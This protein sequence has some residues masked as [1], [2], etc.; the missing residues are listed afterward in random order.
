MKFRMNRFWQLAYPVLVYYLCYNLLY[1]LFCS[2]FAKSCS[3]LFLL[4]AASACTIPVLYRLYRRLPIV[5]EEKQLRWEKL[6]ME[7][8]AISG[9]VFAG[10]M[11]NLLVSRIP[12]TEWFQ[13]YARANETLLTGSFGVKLFANGVSIPILEELLY[14]GILCR[15]MQQWYGNKTAVFVSAFLFGM[16]HFNI[17]QCIYGF[18]MG[19]FL[20]AAYLKTSR[21]WV[22]VAGHGLTNIAVLVLTTFLIK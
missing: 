16:M 22:T 2:L 12:L 6:P 14:R 10:I 19:I 21:L 7:L 9:I 1:I 4:G 15:Q 18:L 5:Y 11:L 17:V 8:L 3:P 20:A 13:G